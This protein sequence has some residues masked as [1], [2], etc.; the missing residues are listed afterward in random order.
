MT[1]ERKS[2]NR[3]P[4]R[5][6]AIVFSCLLMLWAIII[7]GCAAW[8]KPTRSMV[9][10]LPGPLGGC[11][12]FFASLDERVVQDDAIDAG[13]ARI[14]RYPYLR[15]NRF[16][17]S[18]AGEV[19]GVQPFSAWVSRM[20]ALDQSARAAEIANLSDGTVVEL[21]SDGDRKELNRMVVHC[22]ALLK[23]HDFA[24]AS[25]RTQL[26]DQVIV[27]DEYI[28]ARRIVGVYPIS[29]IF[30][31]NGVNRWHRSARKQFS[32]NPP[33]GW[34]ALRYAPAETVERTDAVDIVRQSPRDALG[35]PTYSEPEQKRLLHAFAPIW[36]VRYHSDD[37][38]IGRPYWT[39]DGRLDLDVTQPVTFTRLNF[40]RF[41]NNI[42]TQLNYVVWFPSRPKRSSSD[43]YG[44]LLDGLNYRVTLDIDGSPLLYET[45]HNCGCYYKAYST[46]QLQRRDSIDYAEKP[47]ILPAPALMDPKQRMVVAMESGTHDVRHLYM[48]SLKNEHGDTHYVQADYAVLKQLPF[49]GGKGRSMFN[50][51]G[52]VAGSERLERFVLWP[53]GVLSPGAMRQWGRH[54]V[55]FVG[56]R[57][58][59][60]PFY[61]DRIFVRN[62]WQQTSPVEN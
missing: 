11:A 39:G 13:Y 35:I 34:H 12:D 50:R 24:I 6:Y 14:N 2:A 61:L 44:G 30:V 3:R 20:Q 55:A 46:G 18:F 4:C 23:A 36:Q 45:V 16:I 22:G 33:S 38:R 57:H 19:D 28:L 15:T 7:S 21:R 31:S 41:D 53:T 17:A 40:T 9:M 58:F 8:P 48:H 49:P 60:D 47:L 43:L 1:I 10:G 5:C 52:I 51:Y 54:A 37:D 25:D 62:R 27:P 42:L 29:S 59:D 26:Q 56:K 32:S